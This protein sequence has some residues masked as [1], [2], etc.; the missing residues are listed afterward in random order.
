MAPRKTRTGDL[1]LLIAAAGEVEESWPVGWP[2]QDSPF[3]V[4]PPLFERLGVEIEKRPLAEALTAIQQRVK[5]PFVLDHNELLRQ[6]LDPAA[7]LVSH[8]KGRATYK[9]I[10]DRVLF[11]AKLASDLRVDEAGTPFLWITSVKKG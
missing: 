1:T 6:G 11:Q 9:Q 4:A 2:P 10:L 7:I 5:I 8:P 3:K